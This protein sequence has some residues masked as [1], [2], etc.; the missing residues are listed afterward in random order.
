MLVLKLNT[1]YVLFV[2]VKYV[3]MMYHQYC[4]YFL[5]N[6]FSGGIDF[7]AVNQWLTS[8]VKVVPDN[9]LPGCSQ[10][11]VATTMHAQ[12]CGLTML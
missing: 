9:I 11:W 7:I 8:V 5:L 3:S 10:K 1:I 6:P 4:W 12:A 2:V